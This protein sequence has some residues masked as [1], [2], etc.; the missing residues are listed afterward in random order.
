MED[1]TEAQQMSWCTIRALWLHKNLFCT[2]RC[3]G[4]G[5]SSLVLPRG[6]ENSASYMINSGVFHES[7]ASLGIGLQKFWGLKSP[8]D[9]LEVQ[10]L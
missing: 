7:A 2:I 10:W 9:K 5:A 3:F 4:T 8:N 6:I 1:L